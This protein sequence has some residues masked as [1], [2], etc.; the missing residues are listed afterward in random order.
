MFLGVG[1]KD[2]VYLDE[3]FNVQ[4]SWKTQ[5]ETN[6]NNRK[7]VN[8]IDLSTEGGLIW[9]KNRK[10]TSSHVLVDTVRGKTKYLYSD[11]TAAQGTA[12]SGDDE[13]VNSF[14]TDGFTVG[15]DNGAVG[16]N[17]DQSAD[18]YLNQTFRKVKGFFDIVTWTG[19]GSGVRNISHSLGSIPGCIMVKQTNSGS[20]WRVYHRSLGPNNNIY[21][22]DSAAQ[23]A[24]ATLW[25]NTAPTATQFTVGTGELNVN[26]DEFVAY[27]FAGGASTAATARSVDFDGDDNLKTAGDNSFKFGTG[28]W[29]IEG[30]YKWD[31]L[32]SPNDI[33]YIFDQRNTDNG[34]YAAIYKDSDETLKVYIDSSVRITSTTAVTVNEWYHICLVRSSGVIKLYVN[35]I[36][37][38]SDYSNSSDFDGDRIFIAYS[39]RVG[40]NNSF[41]GF[42]SN[43]R[44]TKSAVYTSSFRLPTEPLTNI[45]NTVLLCCNDSSVTGST[46]TTGAL[47]SSGDP[48]AS[49][50][51]P[52][53]DPAGFKFGESGKESI[54]KCGSH[55]H[56]ST[57]AIKIHTGWAPQWVLT[58]NADA[59]G[60]WGMFNTKS[61][62]YFDSDGPTLV[63]D[64]NNAENGV[65]GQGNQILKEGDGMVFNY[66]LTSLNPGNGQEIIYIAIREEDGYVSKPPEVGTDAFAIDTGNGLANGPNFDATFDPDFVMKTA[67]GS[68]SDKYIGSRYTGKDYVIAN[69]NAAHTS[70]NDNQIDLG[71][72]WGSG[73]QGSGWQS[74]MWRKGKGCD[75][76]CYDGDGNSKKVIAHTLGQVPE[77]IWTKNRDDT[78]NWICYHKGLNGGTNPWT[79]FLKLNETSAEA[80]DSGAWNDTAPTSTH[81]TVG[82]ADNMN[83]DGE[84]VM[85]ILFGSV[86]GISK[87]GYFSGSDSSH[88]ITTGFQPRFVMIKNM[89]SSTQWVM[90]DTTR[91]WTSG[92]Q[93]WQLYLSHPNAHSTAT[94]GH[95]V[96][97]GFYLDGDNS[98]TS[99]A[100]S[101]FLYYAH[102]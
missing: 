5:Q 38:G 56:S 69:S 53:D 3:V 24:Y 61:G 22:N 12:A 76:I 96:S 27:L 49:T 20:F 16:M 90:F 92:A 65:M 1:A 93:D 83:A 30:W 94:F 8:N 10:G 14:N 66:G 52:F 42:I 39:E 89:T 78:D 87:V 25:D 18:L 91:G 54:I 34:H 51:S 41:N 4:V 82:N 72:G 62:M 46:V 77:M 64:G 58:K 47:S 11:S 7:I 80:T 79:K 101:T 45:T 28:D 73:S 95:P 70:H 23:A 33:Q 6:A 21:L 102:A 59:S 100:G 29:T 60:N 67:P 48:T 99:K 85:A 31:S 86:D 36:Q 2:K 50:D 17:S 15:K 9:R 74:W 81:F 35:G 88:T 55:K 63:A 84:G 71:L 19:D 44:V 98:E 13:I 37:E 40:T 75:V 26:G 32:T 68:S 57:N 43:F 97:T